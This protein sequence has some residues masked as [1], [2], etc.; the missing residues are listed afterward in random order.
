MQLLGGRVERFDGQLALGV[1]LRFGAP[2]EDSRLGEDLVPRLA[3]GQFFAEL[4]VRV[5]AEHQARGGEGRVPGDPASVG[6]P[7]QFAVGRR[8][9]ADEHVAL[10]DLALD[11]RR[12]RVGPAAEAFERVARGGGEFRSDGLFHDVQQRAG[13]DRRHLGLGWR[14]AGGLRGAGGRHG[15]QTAPDRDRRARGDTA[16]TARSVPCSA[17]APNVEAWLSSCLLLALGLAPP[18]RMLP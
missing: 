6:R 4:G 12:V 13:E 17:H 9:R 16:I 18:S 5:V 15:G 8:G 3:G 1:R 7:C 2:D 11:R 10:A 14:R